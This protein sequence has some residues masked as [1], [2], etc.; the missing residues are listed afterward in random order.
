MP[1]TPNLGLNNYNR[2]MED[3][4]IPE[5]PIKLVGMHKRR[6]RQR[7]E[8]PIKKPLKIELNENRGEFESFLDPRFLNQGDE[9]LPPRLKVGY[10]LLDDNAPSSLPVSPKRRNLDQNFIKKNMMKVVFGGRAPSL[11]PQPF[12]N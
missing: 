8:N 9:S 3:N 4:Y 1:P 6:P 10:G 11:P 2:V 5:I 12:E 7:S